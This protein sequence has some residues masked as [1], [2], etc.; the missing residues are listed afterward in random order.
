MTAPQQKSWMKL[1]ALV[2]AAYGPALMLAA[3]PE[4]AGLASWFPD[5][6]FWPLD[7]QPVWEG[8]T[9]R[10]ISGVSGGFLVGWGVL[11]W[12]LSGQLFDLAPDIVRRAVVISAC[13]WCVIDSTGSLLAGG[14]LNVLFN[15][16]LLVAIIGPLAWPAR[17]A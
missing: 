16:I 3:R 15:L 5:L 2:I 4:F 6:V 10:F 17:P 9:L 14:G 8:Q 12:V 13:C 7:G 11:V 1:A